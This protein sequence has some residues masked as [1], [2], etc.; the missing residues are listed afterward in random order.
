M[1]FYRLPLISDGELALWLSA[2]VQQSPQ[3]WAPS[4][5][6]L[7]FPRDRL[8]D[9]GKL[10][11]EDPE[12][13]GPLGH[14]H[15]RLG[16]NDNIYYGGHIGY[17]VRE[18]YRGIGLAGRACRLLPPLARAHGMEELIITA[19]PDNLPSLRTIER[20][21]A[22]FEGNVEVPH[23]HDLYRR[24]DRV[25]SRFVWDISKVAPL[26]GLEPS[27]RP[28]FPDKMESKWGKMLWQLFR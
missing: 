22:S 23:Y 1:Y 6:F 25:V 19:T 7:L 14:I 20:L 4:Y 5:Q 12:E 8:D 3:A 17:G 9:N 16:M 28:L 15:L 24:G 27:E 18:P 10:L 26:E 11:F 21:G 2:C 13:A